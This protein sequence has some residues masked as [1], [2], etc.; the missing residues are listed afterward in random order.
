MW[1]PYT[2]TPF[3]SIFYLILTDFARYRKVGCFPIS[4]LANQTIKLYTFMQS[5]IGTK[6]LL[7]RFHVNEFN[8]PIPYRI[9]DNYYMVPGLVVCCDFFIVTHLWTN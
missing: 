8:H 6:K 5:R 7:K 2:I 3:L 1:H 4:F 9:I